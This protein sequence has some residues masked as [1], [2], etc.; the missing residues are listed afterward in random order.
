MF[1][2]GQLRFIFEKL[3]IAQLKNIM[4]ACNLKVSGKK[5]DLKERLTQYLDALRLEASTCP[6]DASLTTSNG[7]FRYYRASMIAFNQVRHAVSTPGILSTVYSATAS[8]IGQLTVRDWLVMRCG[9]TFGPEDR[10]EQNVPM[11]EYQPFLRK[12]SRKPIREVTRVSTSVISQHYPEVCF[13]TEE[14]VYYENMVAFVTCHSWDESTDECVWPPQGEGLYMWVN[15]K[16]VDLNSKRIKKTYVKIRL[17]ETI[18]ARKPCL[19][20]FRG[21]DMKR[22]YIVCVW[23]AVMEDPIMPRRVKEVR[24]TYEEG[25]ERVRKVQRCN[26]SSGVQAVDTHMCISIVDPI[27]LGKIETAARGKACGHIE[28]FDHSNIMHMIER[29]TSKEVKCP[30]CKTKISKANIVKDEFFQRILEQTRLHDPGATTCKISM[31]QEGTRVRCEPGPK[32]NEYVVELID[33]EDDGDTGVDMD[34]VDVA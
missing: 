6:E 21:L 31:E 19:I 30:I 5:Q 18:L 8:M 34:V 11:P 26:A 12:M 7:K 1:S 16:P 20:R 29:S 24:G 25:I 32:P 15:S 14:Y 3:G 4:R 27:T 9:G 13:T 10:L 28:C 23:S 33:D 17:S 22:K 2:D